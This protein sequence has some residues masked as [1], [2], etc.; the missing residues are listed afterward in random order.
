M[1]IATSAHESGPK[2]RR[3]CH[4]GGSA[5]SRA[6]VL[7]RSIGRYSPPVAH[8]S[9]PQFAVQPSSAILRR[10]HSGEGVIIY[11]KYYSHKVKPVG[12]GIVSVIIGLLIT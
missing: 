9:L 7:S 5:P 12:F 1:E 4:F 10:S 2:E 11:K 6:T 8:G 3:E